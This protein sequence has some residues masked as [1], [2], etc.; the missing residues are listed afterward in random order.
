MLEIV[1]LIDEVLCSAAKWLD[2]QA[3]ASA[4]IEAPEHLAK[5]ASVKERVHALTEG[6]PLNAY[7]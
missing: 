3:K 7:Q 4:S 6:K 5:L 2:P 1:N